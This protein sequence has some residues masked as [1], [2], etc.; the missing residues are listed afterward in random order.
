MLNYRETTA[1]LPLRREE[2]FL[3]EAAHDYFSEW[4]G[5]RQPPSN[6]ENRFIRE[7]RSSPE[8][9]ILAFSVS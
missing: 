5:G 1:G 6:F 7:G 4:S 9:R 8:R 2:R 3:D